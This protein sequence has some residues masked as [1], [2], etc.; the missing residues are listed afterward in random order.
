MQYYIRK[1]IPNQAEG[2][3]V[4]DQRP[5][6]I[7]CRPQMKQ[8]ST[9]NADYTKRNALAVSCTQRGQKEWSQGRM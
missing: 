2:M 5:Y 9:S 7:V 8:L 3:E 4:S 1:L 6:F